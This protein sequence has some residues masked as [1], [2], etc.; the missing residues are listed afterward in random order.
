MKTFRISLPFI[1]LFLQG[2]LPAA[3]PAVPSDAVESPPEVVVI[4]Q[5]QTPKSEKEAILILPGF[6]DKHGRRKKQKAF[7]GNVGYD[8]YIPDYKARA[9]LEATVENLHQFY[10]QHDLGAYKKVHVFAYIMGTWVLN[11]YISQYGKQNIATIVYDRSPLQERAPRVVVDRIPGIGKLLKG[12]VLEEMSHTPYPPMT[13]EGINIGIM[14]ESKATNLIKIFK[15]KTLSYG[16]ID[17]NNLQFNQSYHDLIYI[18]LNH[19]QLYSR[20]D[21]VG[22]D[23]LFFLQHGTFTPDARRDP[24]DWDVFKK[25]KA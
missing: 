3:T 21:V 22:Q 1:L 13:M 25:Y 8:L 18:W 6:G 17:W 14:V 5:P 10:E 7:F 12:K 19:D 24:Y 9:S 20:F 4:H 23:I 11:T 2:I 16:P 15:K